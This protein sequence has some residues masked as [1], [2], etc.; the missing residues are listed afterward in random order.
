MAKLEQLVA[1]GYPVF[2]GSELQQPEPIFTYCLFL[3]KSQFL[4]VAALQRG[5]P[6]F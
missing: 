3:W 5:Q 1:P 4:M 2:L 6:L